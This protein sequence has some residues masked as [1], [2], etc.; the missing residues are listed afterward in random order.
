MVAFFYMR[1]IIGVHIVF[2][3]TRLIF[4][5]CLILIVGCEREAIQP[6]EVDVTPPLPASGLVVE[7][8]EDGLIFI[9]WV[10]NTDRD[11]SAYIVYRSE[12]DQNNFRAV[13]TT[14]INYFVDEH[15]SYDTTYFY[16]VTAI[17]VAGNQSARSIIISAKSPNLSSPKSPVNFI[18][19]GYHV[20]PVRFLQLEWK[21]NQESDLTG[22]RIYRSNAS[23]VKID[24]SSL[25]A[26]VQFAFYRDTTI[27]QL[28]TPYYYAVTAID[29]G[30]KESDPSSINGDVITD[31]PQ[32][33]EPVPFASVLGYPTFRWMNVNGATR[34]KVIVSGSELTNEISSFTVDA[35]TSP[36]I[37]ARYR[38]PYLS[39]GKL[40]Y[41]RVAT[42]T[43]SENYPNALSET[44]VFQIVE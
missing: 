26:L 15:R 13:D 7:Q 33:V 19:H 5:T 4:I 2:R 40:Y 42:I 12:Y 36:I 8:A 31:V 38:G 25:I 34:Y 21:P 37:S 30:G 27:S 28:N 9:G 41:W 17:D 18:V 35:A 3:N 44:R 6:D 32:L 39:I 11:L 23:S 29:A 1:S 43:V 24:P 16:Y 20:G 14:A 10:K 22:Y